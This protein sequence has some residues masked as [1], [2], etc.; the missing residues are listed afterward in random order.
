MTHHPNPNVYTTGEV[1]ALCRVAPRTVAKWFD[2]GRL[3]GYRIPGSLDRRIPREALLAFLREHGM[4]I[5][6]GLE[7]D[8]AT[9]HVLTV[10]L[11][12]AAWN[13]LRRRLSEDT[14]ISHQLA[15]SGF[16]AGLYAAQR[17]PDAVV[18]DLGGW[19]SEAV[20]VAGRLRGCQ[21]EVLLVGLAAED[22]GEADG[23]H[24]LF[25][26]VMR[27]PVDVATLAEVIR[28]YAEYGRNGHA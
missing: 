10:G 26:V 13:C 5:P 16:E 20:A 25:D 23:L 27:Q 12:G 7:Q 17:P 22:D 28:R 18:I 2:S 6:L 4:P 19:R 24:P 9:Y 14:G 1:A 15:W 21:P 11:S 8:T 3:R